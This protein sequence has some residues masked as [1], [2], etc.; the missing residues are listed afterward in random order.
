LL[1]A[2]SEAL[3]NNGNISE[4]TALTAE[5]RFRDLCR[6]VHHTIG[7]SSALGLSV[8]AELGARLQREI[9]PFMLL[10]ETTERFYSNN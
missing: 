5:K 7:N 9:L 3:N 6:L 2:D 10:T 8:K 1:Q 4:A